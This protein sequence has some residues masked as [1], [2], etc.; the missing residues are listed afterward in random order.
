M[1]ENKDYLTKSIITYLG[2]KRN[3]LN[4]IDKSTEYVKKELEKEKLTIVDLFS[5]SGI[6]ARNYKKDAELIITNDLEYY[7][8]IINSCF[9]KNKSEIDFEEL[10]YYINDLK[11]KTKTLKSGFI[12]ELYAPVDDK[13]IQEDERVFYT[14]RNANYIDTVR[15]VIEEY[16]KHIKEIFLALLLTESS[17]KTNTSGVF[18]GFYKN[19]KTK[20]GQYGGNSQAALS[21]ILADIEIKEDNLVFSNYEC[22]YKVLRGDANKVIEE[23]PEV[24]LIYMDPPYNQHPYSSNYF[25]L[26]LIAEYKKP[27]EISKVSGIPNNWNRS[28][29]N[30][31][32]ENL[33]NLKEI[34]KKAKAS[35]IVI[36]FSDDGFYS[37]EEL[38]TTLKEAGKV[39]VLEQ[40]YNTF[41]GSR[42]LKDREKYVKELLFVIDKRKENLM[43]KRKNT[44]LN[45]T[46]KNQE[47]ELEEIV[48]KV[49]ERLEDKYNID[50]VFEKKIYISEIVDKLNKLYNKKHC[51]ESEKSFIN[52]DGGFLFVN[53]NNEKLP[54]LISEVKN[55][56]TNDRRIREG[57]KKQAKGNAIERLGKNVIALR[58]FTEK[59]KIFPFVCFGYGCDFEKKSTI[60]DR[61]YSISGFNPMNEINLEYGSFFFQEEKQSKRNVYFKMLKIAEES[62]KHYN[63][64]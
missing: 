6:V 41:R 3:L 46:S 62:L 32:A 2:N 45:K 51:F 34:C 11:E 19:S 21:R 23:L 64:I 58:R 16:P 40:K 28:S 24:D 5:G 25:M 27:E 60:L 55:Q 29:F 9:L 50:I 59:E 33:N 39:E 42:N 30:K 17:V 56:G 36:S 49:K 26:N 12:S 35:F 18:K 47:K 20:K 63:L 22:D 14:T 15:E 57:K 53:V 13:N 48:F 10:K 43:K 54:I 7:N 52:P 37:R 4:F 8:Y 31:K 38:E 44:I 1:E 61:I